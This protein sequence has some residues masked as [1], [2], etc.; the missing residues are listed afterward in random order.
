MLFRQTQER[1]RVPPIVTDA[2]TFATI[3]SKSAETVPETVEA[4]L[5]EL[6]VVA[7]YANVAGTNPLFV[8]LTTANPFCRQAFCC[9]RLRIAG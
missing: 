5:Q 1:V 3:R 2:L 8:K 7:V 4:T 6:D 9:T